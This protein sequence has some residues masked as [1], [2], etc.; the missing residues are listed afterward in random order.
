MIP[1]LNVVPGIHRSE[2]ATQEWLAGIDVGGTFT[3]F[4]LQNIATDV[5]HVYKTQTTSGDPSVAFAEGLAEVCAQASVAPDQLAAVLHG[6]TVAMNAVIEHRGALTGLITTR[7][8]RDI[9]HIGRH[10]RPQHYSIM[11]DIPW[12]AR[13]F[14]E[15]R[16]RKVVTER[17]GPDGAILVGLAEDEVRQAARE[18]TEEGV[19]SVAVCFLFSYRNSVHEDRS[20]EIIREEMGEV[21]VTTSADIAPQFREFERFTTACMNAF[22]GPAAGSYLGRLTRR[23]RHDH[24]AAP[25]R[26]MMSN[27]GLTTSETASKRPVTLMMSGPAAGVVG[28]QRTGKL[29]GRHRLI[30]FDVGGTSAD[31][32]IVTDDGVVEASA[33]DTYVAG[34]PLLVPMVDVH[35]IGAGGGSIARV[36]AGGAFRVGPQSAGADPGPACYPR[37]G[38]EPTV[39]DAN[40]V[41][42]RLSRDL[43]L[44]GRMTL[45]HAA[46]QAAIARLA[47][48]LGLTTMAAAAGIIS[49]INANMAQAIRSLTVQK[50]RDPRDFGLVAFGGAGPLH[51]AE[52]ADLLEIP[53]VIVP[54]YP[55]LTS[56]VGLLASDLK[57]D[58]MRTVFMAEP[59]IDAKRLREQLADLEQGLR[60]RLAADG[61]AGAEISVSRH[62]DCRYTGQGYEL[63][64]P[65]PS[66]HFEPAM[67]VGFH[68]LHRQEYGH[69]SD[70][71]IEVVS[72]RITAWAGNRSEL[73]H[74]GTT[75]PRMPQ[76]IEDRGSIFRQDGVLVSLSTKHLHRSMLTSEESLAGPALL[77]QSDTSTLVPP[78]WNARVADNGMLILSKSRSEGPQ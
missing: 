63:R 47:R 35:A 41:L 74:G 65:L 76:T 22:V 52:V 10:Q 67:L 5:V 26:V 40:L 48:Q 23:L 39:T 54:L 60:G 21:F 42:G 55:G 32:A 33:R 19:E 17:I 64:L 15:R 24:I 77:F 20:A 18:L 71:P 53:E 3:D 61:V 73:I 2:A 31:L 27:G 68:E 29:V 9:I 36:D 16:H 12:Q 30:T 62:L 59:N 49:V 43:F 28:G 4:V 45:S 56:A 6:T 50:G 78:S 46:A 69:A 66:D 75:A 38:T 7:G 1:M 25:F 58:E 51:A 44:G 14:V 72:M 8:F 11:Q 37:G 70:D 13:P 34:F 57:Y